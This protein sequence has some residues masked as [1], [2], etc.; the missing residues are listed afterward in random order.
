MDEESSHK[1]LI[2]NRKIMVLPL[3]ALVLLWG[4]GVSAF[5][6]KSGQAMPHLPAAISYKIDVPLAAVENPVKK[7]VVEFVETPENKIFARHARRTGQM[8][9]S[10][11]QEAARRHQVDPSL[12]KAIIMAESAYDPKAVS[13]VGAKGLMQLMPRTAEAL[14]VEDCFNPEN[15]ING[16]VRY[17]KVLLDR[18]E[19]DEKLALAAYNAG[20]TKV[21]RFKGIPPFKATLLYIDKVLAYYRCYKKNSEGSVSV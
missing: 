18:F 15:N 4:L 13:K 1:S 2:F 11:I 5:F 19:G 7:P 12:V 8:F 6:D 10:V 3:A 17:F 9:H 16:G 14:G 20:V 21:R